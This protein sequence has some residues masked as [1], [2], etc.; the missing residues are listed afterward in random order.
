MSECAAVCVRVSEDKHTSFTPHRLWLIKDVL[1]L[2]MIDMI[3]VFTAIVQLHLLTSL[4]S[5][6]CHLSTYVSL[7]MLQSYATDINYYRHYSSCVAA[8]IGFF[9]PHLGSPAPH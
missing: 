2:G 3:E 7:N 5:S 4:S 1:L 9:H 8:T 6:L